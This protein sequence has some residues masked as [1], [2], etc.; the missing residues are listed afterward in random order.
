M[1]WLSSSSSGTVETSKS[2]T[3]SL[4]FAKTGQTTI[5]QKE[6]EEVTE[7]RGLTKDTAQKMVAVTDS[8]T[9]TTYYKQIGSE[10]YSI[11]V[12]SGTKT[13]ISAARNDESD[14]W[15]ATKRVIT[16][17]TEPD[18]TSSKTA[19]GWSTT[20]P[21]TGTSEGR[22]VSYS[23]STSPVTYYWGASLFSKK[24]VTT[25]EYSGLTQAAAQSLV[26]SKTS[27]TVAQKIYQ[28]LS[29]TTNQGDTARL[30]GWCYAEC[31]VGTNVYGSAQKV[32][33]TEGYRVTI[34]TEVWT[35]D[36]HNSSESGSTSAGSYTITRTWKAVN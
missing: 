19:N 20:Y 4:L 23:S 10:V 32:S 26:Q 36:T 21:T 14:G 2:A 27:S 34:T 6:T 29:Y 5:R 31:T 24:E 35:A 18:L 13:E 15:H 28:C 7:Y 9:Q 25:T 3:T 22:Q 1:S 30:S 17:S 16:Y 11:T 33:D 12:L 8:T